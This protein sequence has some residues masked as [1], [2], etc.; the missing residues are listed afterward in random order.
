MELGGGFTDD[1][2]A[3]QSGSIFGIPVRLKSVFHE[4]PVNPCMEHRLISSRHIVL[5][6][7]GVVRSHQLGMI[8]PEYTRKPAL[9]VWTQ[10]QD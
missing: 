2:F 5:A 6:K 7:Q 1:L 4:D 10:S 8:L 9:H 3:G